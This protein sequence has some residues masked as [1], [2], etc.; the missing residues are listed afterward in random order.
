MTSRKIAHKERMRLLKQWDE[1]LR[2]V[3]AFGDDLEK[4]FGCIADSRAHDV[5]YG[6]IARYTNVVGYLTGD[7]FGW[8]EWY[9]LEN[10]MGANEM[11]AKASHWRKRQKIKNLD[12]L[13]RL[14][15]ADLE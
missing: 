12:S 10:K 6:V 1:Q 3:D 2:I 4:M 5:I 8:L 15:E 7:R 14:I 11:E 13:C 9:W